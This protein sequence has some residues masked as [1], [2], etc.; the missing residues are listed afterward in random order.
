[1]KEIFELLFSGMMLM[2]VG[3]IANAVFRDIF[4][5]YR[6]NTISRLISSGV[7]LWEILVSKILR[8]IVICWI[9]ELLL[10]LFTWIVFDVGW[11]DPIMLFIILTSFNLFLTGFLALVY[12]YSR[13]IDMANGIVTLFLMISA[14]LGGG[15]IPFRDLPSAIQTV[16]QWT[17]IRIGNYGIES[18][19]R[20]R[21][22]WEVLRP[23]LFLTAAGVL[24]IALGTLAIR[25]R[26]ESGKVV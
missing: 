5:E 9:C 7:A 20:S 3:F 14:M 8:C 17:M 11:R 26:F 25:K 2:W 23:S 12:G 13:S 4:E 15:F 10:I 22:I 24:F 16:G 18:I 19:F 21:A 6:A 1:M